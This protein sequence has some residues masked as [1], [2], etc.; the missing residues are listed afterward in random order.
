MGAVLF[1]RSGSVC[2]WVLLESPRSEGFSR[3]RA[4]LKLIIGAR[5]GNGNLVRR[6][7]YKKGGTSIYFG[8]QK[9]WS[10][11]ISISIS[12]LKNL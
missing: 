10:Q 4:G 8:G 12:G 1:V 2:V 9:F 11:S 3:A 5:G 6:L 7:I